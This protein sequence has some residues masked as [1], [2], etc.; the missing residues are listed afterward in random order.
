MGWNDRAVF[1]A[2]LA[3]AFRPKVETWNATFDQPFHLFRSRITAIAAANLARVMGATVAESDEIPA[4]ALVLPVDDDDWFS[5]ETAATLQ[6]WLD[7]DRDAFYWRQNVLEVPINFGHQVFLWRRAWFPGI[8]PRW[9]CDTNNYALRKSSDTR[10]LLLDHRRA[11]AWFDDVGRDRVQWLPASLSVTN[12][13]LAS[14]TSLAFGRPRV[15]RREL[16]R[17]YRRYCKLYAAPLAEELA[18]SRPYVAEMRRI[19]NDLELRRG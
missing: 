14:K 12:R 6:G 16:V 1:E 5:P 15:T 9:R 7:S 3:P 19:M 2:Q 4:G 8:P 10:E 11:S 13:T 18:W 17:K